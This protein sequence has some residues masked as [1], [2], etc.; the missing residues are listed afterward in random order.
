MYR[1]R[2][3]FVCTDEEIRE[4]FKQELISFGY[5][6]ILCYRGEEALR[7]IEDQVV[8]VLIFSV[9]LQDMNGFEA[10][11]LVRQKFDFLA[12]P[13]VIHGPQDSDQLRLA[14]FRA[15]ANIFMFA[16]IKFDRLHYVLS[17]LVNGRRRYK[18][19]LPAEEFLRIVDREYCAGKEIEDCITT[20][21]GS[22]RKSDILRWTN[23]LAK[24]SG[25]SKEQQLIAHEMINYTLDLLTTYSSIK[26]VLTYLNELWA[27]TSIWFEFKKLFEFSNGNLRLDTVDVHTTDGITGLVLLLCVNL[28]SGKTPA[29]AISSLY[30]IEEIN[31]DEVEVLNRIISADSFMNQIFN[32]IE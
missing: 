30:E 23:I 21:T 8:D 24:E 32:Q 18:R 2:V 10:C 7:I 3:L 25:L 12:C 9:E 16:P 31:V 26:N 17:L 19:S 1:P 28:L 27:G 29:E 22:I 6:T 11:R 13:V 5:E 20:D 14:A 4:S 15:G